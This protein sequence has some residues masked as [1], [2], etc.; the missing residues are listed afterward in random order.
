MET[1]KGFK[2][3][4]ADEN[5]SPGTPLCAGCGGLLALRLALK[6]LGKNVVIVNAAGCFT[7]LSVY[8]YTPF[9]SSWMYTAMAC[10]PAGAQGIRDALDI[11]IRKGKLKKVEKLVEK[12]EIVE[13]AEKF[14][15]QMVVGQIKEVKDHPNADSLYLMQ[16]DFGK[17]LGK[18]Q[19]VAGLKKWFEVDE[20]V[21]RKAVFC[22]N[23]KPAKLR[24]ELSEGMIFAADDHENVAILD[25]EKS[26]L[27]DSVQFSGMENETKEIT[28]DDFKKVKMMVKEGNVFYKE[29][30]LSTK[31]EDVTVSGVKE[32][33]RVH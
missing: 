9:S 26:K 27:G 17:K 4:S 33:C 25:V 15:L 30:K 8:P 19:V 11:L 7:L 32:G 16:V 12:V 10:A 29:K 24:G 3:I 23:M 13:T 6:V 28:F 2:S 1:Y 14:P 18:R 31:V 22:A 21:G 5:I 20:L